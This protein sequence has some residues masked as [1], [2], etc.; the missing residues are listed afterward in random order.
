[1]LPKYISDTIEK[2][3][4]L[5]WKT[6][7]NTL[8]I[9]KHNHGVVQYQTKKGQKSCHAVLVDLE[10]EVVPQVDGRPPKPQ[11]KDF[12]NTVSLD[13]NAKLPGQEPPLGSRGPP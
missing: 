2:I 9:I 11:E 12:F 4:D 6:F 5:R 8:L 7:F 3:E 13:A 10:G 1:M